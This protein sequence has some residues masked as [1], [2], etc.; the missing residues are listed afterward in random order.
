MAYKPLFFFFKENLILSWSKSIVFC[1]EVMGE[2]NCF[3]T[4]RDVGSKCRA[5]SKSVLLSLL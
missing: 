3:G 1:I 2:P 5:A 4:D